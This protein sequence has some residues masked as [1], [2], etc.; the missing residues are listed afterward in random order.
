MC[1]YHKTSAVLMD[2][3]VLTSEYATAR[4]DLTLDSKAKQQVHQ[5]REV[6]YSILMCI[7][8]CDRP[9]IALLPPSLPLVTQQIHCPFQP[10]QS[11]SLAFKLIIDVT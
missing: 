5:N 4:I 11:P 3:F 8:L 2:N 10:K 7:E 1:E 9:A 6:L